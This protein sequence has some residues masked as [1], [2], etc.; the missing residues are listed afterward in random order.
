[1]SQKSYE[2]QQEEQK[3]R[4]VFQLARE[5]R[6]KTR[7]TIQ[8]LA[9]DLD[10][11]RE[12]IDDGEV[13]SLTLWHNA[14]SQLQQY[15]RE[16]LRCE[17]ACKQPYFGRI[18]LVG[19]KQKQLETYYIGRVGIQDSEA[20]PIVID[21]RAPVASVY[22]E[23]GLG[24]C[25]YEVKKEGNFWVDLKR[26]RT[27]EIEKEQLVDYYDSDVVAN[28]DLLNRYLAK[29]KKAVLGEIIATIQKEQNAIIRKSPRTNLII[30]GVAGSGKTTVA[31]HR[32]S[33]IL[34]NFAK[35]FR[36]EDFYIVGS[37]RI[38]LDYITSALPDLD[39]YGIRQLTMEELFI[40]LLYEDWEEG[41][42]AICASHEK[43]EEAAQK[44][45]KEWYEDLEAFC[46]MYEREQIPCEQITSFKTGNILFEKEDIVRYL[47]KDPLVSMQNKI[48]MLNEILMAHYET[49]IQG[50]YISYSKEEKKEGNRRYKEYF[51]KKE[52]KG[53]IYEL[54]ERFLEQQIR[55]G[56]KVQPLLDELDVYDLAA[57][58]Y[59]YKRIKESDGIRE[60]SHVVI[61]EA[62][63]F[64]MMVYEVLHYC[65]TDCTYTIMGDVSQNIHYT[66]GLNDWE[67]LK[68]LILTGPYDGFGVLSKS[69]RNTVEISEFATDILLH[70]EFEVYPI[71]PIL[72]H[73]EKVW[74][75]S[76]KTK[77]ELIGQSVQQI[78]EWQARGWE[79][80]AVVCRDQEQVG[81]VAKELQAHIKVS[82]C[83]QKNTVFG[84][85]V[86]VVS[87]AYTK[88]LEFDAVLLY[89]PDA[90]SFPVT[91]GNVKL[92][93]VAA[94]RA[95][96][97][98]AVV[99]QKELTPLIEQSPSAKK[100]AEF[101][102]KKAKV[103]LRD[104][105]YRVRTQ[106]EEEAEKILEGDRDMRQR[107]RIG[108]KRIVVEKPEPK[109]K[110]REETV[111]KAPDPASTVMP[112]AKEAKN[113]QGS[114]LRKV[115]RKQTQAKQEGLMNPSPFKYGSIPQEE[116]LR[117]KGHSRTDQMIRWVYKRKDGLE[118][119]SNYGK[120]KIIPVT[121]Q[122]LRIRFQK[123]S[124]NDF[125]EPLWKYTKEQEV[126]WSAKQSREHYLVETAGLK[127]KI[128]KIN[129]SIR[130]LDP[131]GQLLLAEREKEA[132]IIEE[133]HIS[134]VFFEWQKN[135]KLYTRG[136]LIGD[137]DRIDSKARYFSFGKR[138][139]RLPFLVS[140]KGY[141]IGLA[142]PCGAMF[143]NVKSYGNYLAADCSDEI[144]YFFCYGKNTMEN[145]ELQEPILA[146]KT[147]V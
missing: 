4:E 18:D 6:D 133:G 110:K 114:V 24:R 97:E 37:N 72:R 8:E 64:G 16:I 137:M 129:G 57:L 88:G 48:N 52:W 67:E 23:S 50:K 99:H 126:K 77:K 85:G 117:P 101:E 87:I 34:Y 131:N 105:K 119:V 98:L 21:W 59:L 122:I 63:D 20:D 143:S 60:A 107:H 111:Q 102:A 128:H 43:S 12:Q 79:T 135:E 46:K 45:T 138:S 94:T 19:E 144:D 28:D 83:D 116:L 38:L 17:K 15:Q 27:Y 53:S 49:E 96:H 73:G 78:K 1:M 44:G 145:L 123:G 56:R 68:T 62:Q 58:A 140:E 130:F 89:E 11:M 76:C 31:M 106:K 13:E 25:S 39:V 40:R 91:D 69:Y 142:A 113:N 61:D 127:I 65:M 74:I 75:R 132:H 9:V 139:L 10:E 93:Y 32:I 147:D 124:A 100:R 92:L 30:Q 14:E 29:N 82:V 2:F 7:A 121:D 55:A 115:V 47:E 66:Y 36:P 103:E 125:G 42:Y 146:T 84:E 80:I 54:Y 141:A 3:L 71:E 22:Y 104:F 35:E 120:L 51:G 112:K 90:E 26:K 95:L 86:T 108:P 118:L 70:G 81:Q 5:K 136:V 33:Y 109:I 134:R 41:R